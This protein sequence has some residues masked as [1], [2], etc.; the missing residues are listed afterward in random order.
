MSIASGKPSCPNHAAAVLPFSV[1]LK[2]GHVREA[3]NDTAPRK[4]HALADDAAPD[5]E[6]TVVVSPVFDI[7]ANTKAIRKNRFIIMH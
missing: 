6:A 7:L 3:P 2:V 1:L 5:K 4:V